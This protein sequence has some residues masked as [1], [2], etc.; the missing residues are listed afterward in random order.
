MTE[1]YDYLIIG[2]G[3][4]GL[5][6]A[7]AIRERDAS[8]SIAIIS[9]ES[10]PL[11]SRV[12][13]PNYVKGLIKREQVFLRK[14]EDYDKRGIKLF[15]GESARHLD[16][17]GRVVGLNS[18][19]AMGFGK[20][21]IATGG[22]AKE[23][24]IPGEALDGVSSFQTIEDAD[25][26]PELLSGAGRGVV[27]GGGFIA[28]EFLEILVERGIK[29]TLV[30]RQPYFFN[31]FLDAAGGEILAENFRRHG[32][33]VIANDNLAAVEGGRR[34]T[35]VHLE[36]GRSLDADFIGIGAGIRRNTGWLDNSGIEVV[37]GG[38]ATDEY[39]ETT[40]SGIFAAGDVA[41]FDDI[42]LGLRHTHGNWGNAF[43]QGGC[44]ARNMASSG[45]REPYRRVT[46]YGIRNLGLALALIGHTSGGKDVD[47][48]SRIDPSGNTYGRFFVR[49][50]RIVGAV[51]INRHD[52]RPAVVS[53]I[54]SAKRV[55][56]E[57]RAGLLDFRVDIAALLQ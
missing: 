16:V 17:S 23:L 26:M 1:R 55:S 30:I 22:D 21:L 13:L 25:R 50:D 39:L 43:Y 14:S 33:D 48:I 52:D 7:E 40:A 38:V 45:E 19:R 46:S 47:A 5:T 36:S 49:E 56:D 8:A 15:M 9:A 51:L 42:I 6:A 12:L 4:A 2:N 28:L 20:L 54:E 53:L 32:I 24:G 27:I 34:V 11:Y 44:A 31:R 29:A 37:G 41:N 3:I 35:G 10:Y 18:G 57:A